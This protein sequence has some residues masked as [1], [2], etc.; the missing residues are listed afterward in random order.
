MAYPGPVA[1]TSRP[2]R[3]MTPTTAELYDRVV[4]LFA[5][6]SVSFADRQA[7]RAAIEPAAQFDSGV[8]LAFAD[9]PAEVQQLIEANEAKPQIDGWRSPKDVPPGKVPPAEADPGGA[10]V[11]IEQAAPPQRRK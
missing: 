6:R 7:I 3:G 2:A 1:T 8:D 5:T 11:P 10:Y 9:L 4:R